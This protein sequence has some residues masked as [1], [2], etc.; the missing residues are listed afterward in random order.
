MC[1]LSTA[2]GRYCDNKL[3]SHSLRL[4]VHGHTQT[5]LRSEMCGYVQEQAPAR[6]VARSANIHSYTALDLFFGSPALG[7]S[8]IFNSSR[9]VTRAQ[10][11]STRERKTKLD[12]THVR[13][14]DQTYFPGWPT[15][16]RQRLAWSP[17]PHHSNTD[18]PRRARGTFSWP[19]EVQDSFPDGSSPAGYFPP[20]RPV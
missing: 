3:E 17:T 8:G 4:P 6:C 12:S 7:K 10:L 13:N 18:S 20:R 2:F 9:D 14:G 15:G 1:K 11:W 5:R 19:V 16:G